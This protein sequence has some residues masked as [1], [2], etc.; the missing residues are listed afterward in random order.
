M[1]KRK[2]EVWGEDTAGDIHSFQTDDRGT[3]EEMLEIMR[4][5]LERVELTEHEPRPVAE[6]P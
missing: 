3:A 6:R 5:D 4:A 1:S 2:Y